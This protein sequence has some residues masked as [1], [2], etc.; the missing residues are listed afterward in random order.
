M[1]FK[2]VDGTRP[3]VRLCDTCRYSHILRGAQQGQEIVICSRIFDKDVYLPW[4]VVQCSSYMDKLAMSRGEADQIGWVI[5]VKDGRYV[6][7][8]PPKKD[9]Y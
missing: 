5:E 6:G 7:F 9:E 2:V 8:K 3:D 1:G 4:K